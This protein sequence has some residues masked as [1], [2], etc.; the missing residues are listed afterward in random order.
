MASRFMTDP[1]AMRDMAGR[2][3]VHAQ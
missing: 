3:E 1:H 2:F